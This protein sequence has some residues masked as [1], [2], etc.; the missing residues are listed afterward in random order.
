M[1]NWGTVSCLLTL[2]D[3][4]IK[5]PLRLKELAPAV[6]KQLEDQIKDPEL[7]KLLSVRMPQ[8][9]NKADAKEEAFVDTLADFIRDYA[10]DPTCSRNQLPRLISGGTR[11]L[12]P[13]D[14]ARVLYIEDANPQIAD[15]WTCGYRSVC[16]AAAVEKIV[17]DGLPLTHEEIG[18]IAKNL[19]GEDSTFSKFRKYIFDQ[20]LA[21]AAVEV[22]KTDVTKVEE[23]HQYL[24]FKPHKVIMRLQEDYFIIDAAVSLINKEEQRKDEPSIIGD[25]ISLLGKA[26]NRKV[27]AVGADIL[28]SVLKYFTQTHPM[29]LRLIQDNY[30]RFR[31]VA[32]KKVRDFVASK[33]EIVSLEQAQKR[34]WQL[35]LGCCDAGVR[36]SFRKCY[37][38]DNDELSK[39][40]KAIKN[41]LWGL[42]HE[43]DISPLILNHFKA[44]L[45]ALTPPKINEAI[46]HLCKDG[47]L[48]EIRNIFAKKN[49]SPK[50]ISALALLET[51]HFGE[52]GEIIDLIDEG[53]S[54]DKEGIKIK[55]KII[56]NNHEELQN[57]LSSMRKELKK[58]DATVHDKRQQTNEN[59][60][61]IIGQL[62]N[63]KNDDNSVTID[64]IL[65][66]LASMVEQKDV[67]N[68]ENVATKK[69]NKMDK[70]QTASLVYEIFENIRPNAHFPIEAENIYNAEAALE[71]IV[72]SETRKAI[73]I[74]EGDQPD[75]KK[76][77]CDLLKHSTFRFKGEVIDLLQ[78]TIDNLENEVEKLEKKG[79]DE[80]VLVKLRVLIQKPVLKIGGYPEEGDLE[81]LLNLKELGLLAENVGFV[82]G[83]AGRDRDPVFKETEYTKPKL[84]RNESCN[85]GPE[86]ISRVI[87][88]HLKRSFARQC[89]QSSASVAHHSLC[90]T[91]LAGGSEHW[92][93]ASLVKHK[94]QLPTLVVMDSMNSRIPND[95][96]YPM[97]NI[98]IISF[99]FNNLLR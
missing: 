9:W 98:G 88:S 3:H 89:R 90:A 47:R 71:E 26:G 92:I 83:L 35:V 24:R 40:S 68:I 38:S 99:L 70:K 62:R 33:D 66:R 21:A 32:P 10:S 31:V 23:V 37:R 56:R 84:S 6:G 4:P 29:T 76:Q 19:Y 57:F 52:M 8:L 22:L 95:R 55:L 54:P 65:Y 81:T 28:D 44:R 30:R 17:K 86:D 5:E 27:K 74:L 2:A 91:L 93:L 97:G 82:G 15:G 64:D 72:C 85:M 14:L 53:N 60:I 50:L 49:V 11:E 48:K 13:F 42:L 34:I 59:L 67:D 41:A 96:Y 51:P 20:K 36:K 94:S 39:S 63:I 79:L 77:A 73:V 80:I 7:L 87:G 12:T 75:K 61:K 69:I 58:N 25:I 16:N 46:S 43:K 45:L 78:V 1:I 18:R